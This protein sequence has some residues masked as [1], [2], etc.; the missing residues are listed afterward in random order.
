M[1]AAYY[2]FRPIP[3]LVCTPFLLHNTQSRE[4]GNGMKYRQIVLSCVKEI[5]PPAFL[6]LLFSVKFLV[7]CRRWWAGVG[8]IFMWK[9]QVSSFLSLLFTMLL[10]TSYSNGSFL[11]L[12]YYTRNYRHNQMHEEWRRSGKMMEAVQV[13]KCLSSAGDYLWSP[14]LG[15]QSKFL[16]IGRKIG[17]HEIS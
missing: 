16:P 14:I 12:C 10:N 7:F 17:V 4:T 13:F 15:C 2:L 11:I 6:S 5:M 3:C 8:Y 9:E 1:N